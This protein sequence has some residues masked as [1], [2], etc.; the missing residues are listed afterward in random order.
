MEQI[1]ELN[2]LNL[3]SNNDFNFESIEEYLK[4]IENEFEIII[5]FAS[6]TGSRALGTSVENSDFDISGFF[7]GKNKESYLL[8]FPKYDNIIKIVQHQIMINNIKYEIDVELLE[9]KDWLNSKCIK[10]ENRYDYWFTSPLIYRNINPEVFIDK[11]YLSAPSNLY[12]G[13][14]KSAI[15]YNEKDLKNNNLC[16]NKSLMNIICSFFQYLHVQLYN[17]FPNFNILNEFN[18][19]LKNEES[20]TKLKTLF[21]ESQIKI[22]EDSIKL[23]KELLLEKQKERLSKRNNFPEVIYDLS[24]LLTDKFQVK[25]DIKKDK[26]INKLL[27][28]NEAQQIFNKLLNQN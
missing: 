13:K 10:N 20:L 24:K 9:V 14:A 18:F 22:L 25:K 27:D 19:I 12:L 17:D 15:S 23:Y 3:K 2:N 6:E 4:K 5:V 1:N 26:E 21:D 11:I 8:L 16:L 7:I 28:T